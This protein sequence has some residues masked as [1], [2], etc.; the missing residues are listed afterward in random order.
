[1]PTRPS[2][3]LEG[4]ARAA[5]W[6][7]Y[8]QSML[9][10]MV[11]VGTRNSSPEEGI[12]IVI[13]RH[14]SVAKILIR[15]EEVTE[16]YFVGTPYDNANIGGWGAPYDEDNPKGTSG[17]FEN[18]EVLITRTD[19]DYSVVRYP[20]YAGD[21]P[22]I[23]YGN[24]NWESADGETLLS[25]DGDNTPHSINVVFPAPFFGVCCTENRPANE[26]VTGYSYPGLVIWQNTLGC[27]IGNVNMA[28]R[29]LHV[30]SKTPTTYTGELRASNNIYK[31]GEILVTINEAGEDFTGEYGL[32]VPVMVLGAAVQKVTED[33]GS[34]T[35]YLVALA[36]GIVVSTYGSYK[37]FYDYLY[38][39]PMLDLTNYTFDRIGVGLNLG[40][41]VLLMN[42]AC[43]WTFN[44]TG[45]EAVRLANGAVFKLVIDDAGN[46]TVTN[47]WQTTADFDNWTGGNPD[48]TSVLNPGD[49][50]RWDREG[51]EV[52][53]VGYKNDVIRFA[54]EY[55]E[56]WAE[57]SLT[58]TD[59]TDPECDT[60]TD[61]KERYDRVWLTFT[62]DPYSVNSPEGI[63]T[64]E[65]HRIFSYDNIGGI[66]GTTTDPARLLHTYK[67]REARVTMVV[68]EEY[69]ILVVE[70]T[71]VPA[72]THFYG[73]I[74]FQAGAFL[75]DELAD[76]S[77]YIWECN[78]EMYIGGA[79]AYESATITQTRKPGDCHE[80]SR[81]AQ[82]FEQFACDQSGFQLILPGN[83]N[84]QGDVYQAWEQD[85]GANKFFFC[86]IQV[87]EV[88][89]EDTEGQFD[90]LFSTRSKLAEGGPV[91]SFLARWNGQELI[92]KV[93][94]PELLGIDSDGVYANT[95]KV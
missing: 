90:I 55:K 3:V 82:F 39:A 95:G 13:S 44:S 59:P 85:E 87:Q 2:I 37:A 92:D 36:C 53:S 5:D 29:V 28:Q 14:G 75:M 58:L 11:G 12:T 42:E 50:D 70:H 16:H 15:A 27:Y 33:D 62:D 78:V 19:R 71:K 35:E 60:L 88:T 22:D 86:N 63:L 72:N 31:D 67:K 94:I 17:S 25:W 65:H 21:F 80:T 51:H 52:I 24:K 76:P 79:L 40:E 74:L 10:S 8:A 34:V 46:T 1:M 7:P 9:A 61:K 81:Y 48:Y 66:N 32:E 23:K 91:D 38:R 30:D 47:L 54:V 26:W 6:I 77:T 68:N 4:A 83:P 56:G 69:D 57:R 45:K 20:A 43:P 18:P 84:Y 64:D 41:Q 93:D 73:Q 89:E 49:L